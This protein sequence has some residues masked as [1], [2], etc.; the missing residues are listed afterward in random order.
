MVQTA[1]AEALGN[2]TW[3]R[4]RIQT[5]SGTYLQTDSPWGNWSGSTTH[6]W[7]VPLSTPGFDSVTAIAF[8][9]H[10]TKST[11]S[12]ALYR[13][14]GNCSQI[15][16]WEIISVNHYQNF[17]LEV[18]HLVHWLK[19]DLWPQTKTNSYWF[20]GTWHLYSIFHQLPAMCQLPIFFC[21]RLH[22]SDGQ[23]EQIRWILLPSS[24]R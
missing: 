20:A 21:H 6:C 17:Y 3:S 12:H 5:A 9:L 10:V 13:Y 23:G 16:T 24:G 2:W 15:F 11:A 7:I 18:M 8:F 22:I 1:Q 4:S 14:W 19:V